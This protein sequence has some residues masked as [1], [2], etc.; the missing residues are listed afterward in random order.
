MVGPRSRSTSCRA[1]A[2]STRVRVQSSRTSATDASSAIPNVRSRSEKRSPLPAASEPTAAPATT[3]SS[4]A[5]SRS[6]RSRSASRC[7]TVNTCASPASI[8]AG[9]PRR[10][11][12][13]RGV[14]A[15]EDHEQRDGLVAGEPVLCVGG[16]EH[17]VPL[18]DA[19]R[20]AV[21]LDVGRA[22]ED[23]V[24]LVV[25]VRRLTVGLGGYEDVDAELE[26]GRL[27]DDLVPATRFPEPRGR[28]R[29]VEA[30]HGPTLARERERDEE[31]EDDPDAEG[32]R[33]GDDR[34]AIG[35]VLRRTAAVPDRAPELG[36]RLRHGE[37]D[38]PARE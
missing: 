23:D 11:A 13:R 6:T 37:A 12:L 4:S 1:S 15:V 2:S 29:D 14:R 17:G 21:D 24:D 32:E 5:A 26:P 38:A 36:E 10:G 35:L 3:R 28:G 33:D 30:L 31:R 16:D 25:A 9:R 22:L 18:R 7:S 34:E 19:P 27:M 20:L 8:S